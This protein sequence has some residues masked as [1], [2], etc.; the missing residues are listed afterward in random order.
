MVADKMSKIKRKLSDQEDKKSGK[1]RKSSENEEKYYKDVVFCQVLK[2]A[3]LTLKTGKTQNVLD[4]DQAAFQRNLQIALK[5]HDNFPSVLDEFVEGFQEYIEDQHR[6]HYCLLPTVTS[7]KCESARCS[8]QDSVVRLLIGIDILQSKMM[9]CLLEKLAEFME[10]EDC[11][12][13]HGEKVNLPKLLMSQFRWLDRIL[14][15]KELADKMLEMIT[16][17]SVDIQREIISCLPEVVEDSEHSHVATSLRDLLMENSS[18]TV[19]ILDA[20]SNLNLNPELMAEVR[21]SVLQTLAS[22]DLENLPVV[23]RFLLQSVTVADALEVVSEIRQNLDFAPSFPSATSTPRNERRQLSGDETRGVESLT[24]DAIKSGI[25]FQKSVAEAWIKAIDAVKQPADHKVI[26]LF[27]LLILYSTDRKKPVESLTR[28]KIRSGAFTEVLLQEAFRERAQE[29][30]GNLVTHFGSGFEGETDSSLDILYQLVDKH[31]DKMAP[32]AIFVKVVLDYLD[33]LGVPQIRKLYSLLSTLAFRSS[34]GG[35]MIQDDLHIIIRKQLSNDNPKYKRMGIIGAVMVVKSIA[36]NQNGDGDPSQASSGP[37]TESLYKQVINLLQLV[38]TSSSRMSEGA[39]LFM[40]ELANVVGKG[41]LDMKVEE[42]ITENVTTDFQDHYVVDMDETASDSMVPQEIKFGLD[43]D[44]EVAI[45]IPLVALTEKSVKDKKKMQTQK[46]GDSLDPICLSPHFRLLRMCE[47]RQNRNLDNIDALLGCPI[48]LPKS[49][50][51]DKMESLSMKEKDV[52]CTSLFHALN[53]FREVVNAFATQIDPEMK[54][55]VITRLHNITEVSKTLEQCLSVHPQFR[56][57]P[58]TFDW[59]ENPVLSVPVNTNTDGKKK[60]R[61]PVKKKKGDK[62]N[63]RV[64]DSDENSKDSSQLDTQN[65]SQ[66]PEKSDTSERPCVDMANYRPFF[67]EL[68]ISVF[69]ILHTGMI[70]KSSLDTELNTKATTELRIQP[71]QLEFL[72]EDFTRKLSHAMISSTSKRKSFLKSKS[73][74]NVGF[75]HLDQCTPKFIVKKVVKLLPALCEHLESSSGFF[76]T[77]IVEND[78]LIDG[79][80][81]NSAEAQTVGSCFHLLLQSLQTIFAWNGFLMVENKSLL[82][83]GLMTLVSRIKTVGSTQLSFQEVLKSS[84]QYI[85]NFAGT[86]PKLGTGVMLIKLM[87]TLAEKSDS[88]DTC[89]K[90]ATV[91]QTFLKRE[92]LDAEGQREKGAKHNENLQFLLKTYLCHCEDFLGAAEEITTKGVPDLLEGDKNGFSEAYPTLTKTTFSV[93]YKT[94]FNELV[95]CIKNIHP[96]KQREDRDAKLDKLLKWNQAVRILHIMVNLMKAFDGRGNL[97]AALKCGRQFIEVF[98]RQGMPLLDTM[99]RSNREDVQGL[100]KNLQLSTRVLHHMCGHSKII[101][102]I[103]L[104]NQVPFLKKCLEAFVYRVKAML[105]MNRCLEAF[106]LGNLKNRDLHGE[107][108]LS[109]ASTTANSTV[110]DVEENEE[111][112]EESDGEE[113]DVE[114]DSVA[115]DESQSVQY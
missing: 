14:D 28:N 108:I 63:T 80:G 48:F 45:G 20:F 86:V 27:I 57:P 109:Q 97:G 69:T 92:W 29:I 82:K 19:P 110:G 59:Y 85:E 79:P 67:R 18:L 99:F 76:Q 22:V 5:R 90:T 33:N 94:V 87:L 60:G 56:P 23:V 78:G 38:R 114:V 58:A 51:M 112:E 17:V 111:E 39:A 77:L 10:N 16:I 91:A 81:S 88:N 47:Q 11:I 32:F 30:V 49:E 4:C 34:Q 26:D 65:E 40:D 62:E 105:T 61:K 95:T 35:N 46:S 102:D 103:A 15:S 115:S 9:M 50:V 53:W 2:K 8:S 36:Y 83:E 6:L 12:V 7:K 13:E 84:F 89:V 3:G 1:K 75:S 41:H 98:L 31:L 43:D 74:K 37:L 106:W 25:R 104:T 70:T 93:Y 24:L 96:G 100:L 64:D 44:S 52:I 55:K 42:W 21:G 72:L 73:D 66:I 54:G 68:D 107:E 113:S 71:P 101:K